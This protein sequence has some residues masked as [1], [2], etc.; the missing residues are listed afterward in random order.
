MA[1][2]VCLADF[3]SRAGATLPADVWDFVAGGSGA[4][5]TLA[6]NRAAL[7]AVAVLPRVL[8]GSGIGA[9]GCQL[10]KDEASMPVA[11]APMAYQRLVHRDGELALAAAARDT[12]IPY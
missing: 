1:D 5:I 11:T 8:A 7:D 10:L 9:T 2:P 4:E 3:E 12:G 6:A